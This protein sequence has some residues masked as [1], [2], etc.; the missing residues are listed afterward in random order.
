MRDLMQAMYH[1]AV[2]AQNSA[3]APN[4]RSMARLP[5]VSLDNLRLGADGRVDPIVYHTWKVNIE[6][7]IVNMNLPEQVVIQLLGP[8]PTCQIPLG[9]LFRMPRP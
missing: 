8:S 7:S 6:D 3:S 5:T 4:D 9:T 1:L 2:V